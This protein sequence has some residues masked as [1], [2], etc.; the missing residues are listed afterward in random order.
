MVIIAYVMP[1]TIQCFRVLAKTA[2]DVSG[3]ICAV[4]ILFQI[5]GPLYLKEH[6]PMF[7]FTVGVYKW[8]LCRVPYPCTFLTYWNISWNRSGTLLLDHLYINFP[9]RY[10]LISPIF[11]RPSSLNNGPVWSRY[12]E[13]V[14]ILIIRFFNITQG[15]Y[16][17]VI[18]VAPHMIA[19]C[20][21]G[22]YKWVIQGFHGITI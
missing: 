18:C 1:I 16:I 9:S 22:I 8:S 3:L 2:S 13:M 12:L 4:R 15:V 5:T 19:V 10:L 14:I 6:F 11:R 17:R 20:E 21:K 7:V